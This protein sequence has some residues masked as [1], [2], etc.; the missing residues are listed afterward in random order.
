MAWNRIAY[1]QWGSPTQTLEI[2]E[3]IPSGQTV[4]TEVEIPVISDPKLIIGSAE[5]GRTLIAN[6]L[7]SR[8][9]FS[10]IDDNKFLLNRFRT[11]KDTDTPKSFGDFRVDLLDGANLKVRYSLLFGN[12]RPQ[13]YR[14]NPILN[15]KASDGLE[16][17]RS[18]PFDLTE[19]R[20]FSKLIYDLLDKIGHGIPVVSA[21]SYEHDDRKTGV[22]AIST[23]QVPMGVW[24]DETDDCYAVLL[25]ILDFL[26]MQVFMQNGEWHALERYMRDGMYSAERWDNDVATSVNYPNSP[27]TIGQGDIHDKPSVYRVIDPIPGVRSILN[28][29][30]E[31][32]RNEDFTP[33][34]EDVD[35]GTP[36]RVS[37]GA[38]PPHWEIPTGI[39]YY[40]TGPY[41]Q[42]DTYL[43]ANQQIDR[44]DYYLVLREE[45]DTVRQAATQSLPQGAL[46]AVDYA[47]ELYIETT[48]IAYAEA[49]EDWID[50]RDNLLP[51]IRLGSDAGDGIFQIKLT[52]TISEQDYWLDENGQWDTSEQWIRIEHR[53]ELTNQNRYDTNVILD[54]VIWGP[55]FLSDGIVLPPLPDSGTL[56]LA[57]RG[58]DPDAGIILPTVSTPKRLMLASIHLHTLRYEVQSEVDCEEKPYEARSPSGVKV[59]GDLIESTWAIGDLEECNNHPSGVLRYLNNSDEWK[60][61]KAWTFG[62]ETKNIH[63]IRANRLVEQQQRSTQ[64]VDMVLNR[65]VFTDMNRVFADSNLTYVPAYM[66]GN[67]RTGITRLVGT[68]LYDPLANRELSP[69][70]VSFPVVAR[71]NPVVS[72]RL[73][74]T[75]GEID[76]WDTFLSV[77]NDGNTAVVHWRLYAGSDLRASGWLVT[78]G[79]ITE[80]IVNDSSG[81]ITNADGIAGVLLVVQGYREWDGTVGSGRKGRAVSLNIPV[82]TNGIPFASF[83]LLPAIE[84][85]GGWRFDLQYNGD[86]D[87][88]SVRTTYAVPGGTDEEI[89]TSNARNAVIQVNAANPLPNGTTTTVAVQAFAANDAG[90][91]S[92][93]AQT[94][95][96]QAPLAVDAPTINVGDIS[97]SDL[98]LVN[99]SVVTDIQFKPKSPDIHRDVEWDDGAGGNPT[100]RFQN[101]NEYPI[102]KGDIDLVTEHGDDVR[103]WAYITVGPGGSEVADGTELTLMF[104][105]TGSVALDESLGNLPIA[106]MTG[107]TDSDNVVFFVPIVGS[108]PII[109]AIFVYAHTLRAIATFTGDLDVSGA[110]TMG[111]DGMI[112]NAD[113]TYLI[114]SEGIRLSPG[115]SINDG[116]ILDS[117]TITFGLPSA[118]GRIYATRYLDSS[119]TPPGFVTGFVISRGTADQFNIVGNPVLRQD[120]DIERDLG[121]GRDLEA[122]RNVIVLGEVQAAGGYYISE[123]TAPATITHRLYRVADALY[124][125]GSELGTGGGGGTDVVANPGGTGLTALTTVTIGGTDYEVGSGTVSLA[126][127]DLTDVDLSGLGLKTGYLLQYEETAGTWNFGNINAL[128]DASSG[129]SATY[130][131]GG[132]Y[133]IILDADLSDLNDVSA[134]APTDGQGLFWNATDG[135][136]QPGDDTDTDTTY[137]AGV[138]LDID[139]NNEISFNITTGEIVRVRSGGEL[140]INNGG[141]LDINGTVEWADMFFIHDAATGTGTGVDAG[142]TLR[143]VG[144]GSATVTLV[145]NTFTFAATDTDTDTNFYVTGGSVAGTTLTLTREGLADVTIT[146]LPSGGGGTDVDANPGGTPSNVLTTVTIDGVDYIVATGVASLALN[147]L[148]DVDS[149][150][151]TGYILERD[152]T[153]GIWR[154]RRLQDLIQFTGGLSLGAIGANNSFTVVLDAD[155]SQL[156]DVSATAPTDG[157]GL[158]WNTAAGEWQPG[159]DTDTDT[160]YTAGVGLDLTGTEFTL[161]AD[162]SDLN[163]VSDTAPTTGQ[164]LKWDGSAWA[165]ADDA[166]TD[167]DTNNYVTG[168]SV[169][170]TTL[171]LTRE[172]LADVTITGLPSGGGG[173]TYTAGPGISIE[174][175]TISVDTVTDSGLYF[176]SGLLSIALKSNRGLEHTGDA[177]DPG[178]GIKLDSDSGLGLS[179]DGLAINFSSQAQVDD[180]TSTDTAIT[181]A[182]LQAKLAGLIGPGVPTSLAT[183]NETGSSIDVSWDAPTS[184]AAVVDYTVE[185]RTGSDAYTTHTLSGTSY[186]ITGLDAGTTYDIRVR[187]N[188]QV[189]SS[190]YATTTAMTEAAPL[191]L[192]DAPLNLTTADITATEIRANW[193]APTTGGAVAGYTVEWRTGSDA[194]TTADVAAGVLT[195]FITGLDAGSEY[196]IRVR[197]TNATGN[198]A[199]ATTTATT[200]SAP[201]AP[202]GRTA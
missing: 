176:A 43:Q 179:A 105:T 47:I 61:A 125:N 202:P 6:H 94:L 133:D 109:S 139:S 145:G 85:V 5:P 11:D 158:F 138:G 175:D 93:D 122:V 154:K 82:P 30:G 140:Q 147:D 8:L 63:F 87:V 56:E 13:I 104:T 80:E 136:W 67:I 141:I 16:I 57:A 31:E 21:F 194:Y 146:G 35:T 53:A 78:N 55:I 155:I 161:D 60:P 71:P 153:D 103:V 128:I 69:Q 193:E 101:G 26:G 159:D 117:N 130:N 97:P 192:P 83:N 149:T 32:I 190:V 195:Y 191:A 77:V 54:R 29:E 201:L 19:D 127:G 9:E 171:T 200:D 74:P 168:G 132:T 50:D 148:T 92:S 115:S 25:R 40:R 107:Y 59:G 73:V 51:L 143:F 15:L 160:T 12:E 129:V 156:N 173:T 198:S 184:G 182:T 134:T 126:L 113:E 112:T 65:D 24:G 120:I 70:I 68:E 172:G 89:I 119:L 46:V 79:A 75:Y 14:D 98:Y 37:V 188:G 163:D 58:A 102:T 162:L 99:Q 76:K 7:K 197:S 116:D 18:Q 22:P 34:P 45:D 81:R 39:N 27:I 174:F 169:A 108:P 180:G 41:F 36:V 49:I 52:N 44:G 95:T 23:V 10:V 64:S 28:I 164:V 142:D 166:D 199:Y 100:I 91:E 187:A 124:W 4:P 150:S 3:D 151:T 66:E 181:P 123:S 131:D 48:T 86:A 2:H 170:G 177:T 106:L 152:A 121:V 137:T 185:W 114:N 88:Q 189:V 178:I 90:G 84:V 33:D 196:D 110:L 135:E 62:S 38:I 183:D 1:H 111:A 157:Q 17:L 42:D 118:Q 96:L 20:T 72:A 167:T 144:T 165:P 186:T